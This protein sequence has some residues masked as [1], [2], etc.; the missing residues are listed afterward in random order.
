MGDQIGTAVGGT[1]YFVSF[2]E[3]TRVR[4]LTVRSNDRVEI[5]ADLCRIN[6]LYMIAKAGSGHIGS[7]FSSMDIM[8][9]LQMEELHDGDEAVH[10]AD[11]F[12]SSKG[13]DAPALY[14]TLIGLGKLDFDLLHQLRRLDGLPGHPDVSTPG[15][16]TNTGSLGMGISKAKGMLFA[17]KLLKKGGRAYVLTGDGELQEGQIWESLVSA[18]N[19]GLSD[20]IVIVDHN[21]IQSD[22]LVSKVSDLGDLEA[23]FAAFGWHVSRCDGN[24]IRDFATTLATVKTAPGKPKVII[25]DTVKGKGVSFME[26]T[27]IDSDVE[28]YKFHSGAP[29]GDVYRQAVQE[30]IDGAN[31]KLIRIGQPPL[32]LEEVTRPIAPTADHQQRLVAAYSNSLLE[33]ARKNPSIVALDADLILDTGLIPFQKEFPDRFVECGIAEQDMVSQAGG[34]ALQGLLPIV[35]SFGCFL[36]SRPN[37][38]IYNNA[39]E[40]TK[41]I[42]VG[43]LAGVVPGGPGHSHQAVRDISTLA[44]VPGLVIMEPSCEEEVHLLLDWA[45]KRY[46]GCSYLRL[47][48]VPWPVEYSL[49][50]GYIPEQGKGVILLD[51]TDAVV[52]AY[53]PV[54]LGEAMKAAEQLQTRHGI[55][56]KV[57]NMPWLNKLDSEWIEEVL[58]GIDTVVTMD[59]HYFEG[60]LGQRIRS[61]LWGCR[62]VMLKTM[63][64]LCIDD[65]PVCGSVADVLSFHHLD[66]TAIVCA[67]TGIET[68]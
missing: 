66:S 8:S 51:G 38:Q 39:T 54:M 44:A 28:Y 20:L 58:E 49:P 40:R 55:S 26:R 52:V 53:G 65:V 17:R 59:N 67:V 25:A 16:V 50:T 1:L 63:I 46:L 7:S 31:E 24:N 13:H 34:M 2:E 36:S 45:V 14:S 61:V 41:I 35:H 29:S 21:K 43:S 12:F 64:H 15:I 11:I 27:S 62:G 33:Q 68:M 57:I 6:A 3:L 4:N 56:L 9:W 30:L 37:E 42:Y 18:A 60:G 10:D 19:D 32:L 5:F 48:S 47:V 22:T 23:K